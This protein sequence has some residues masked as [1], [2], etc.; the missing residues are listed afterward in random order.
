MTYLLILVDFQ[1]CKQAAISE[2][3]KSVGYVRVYKK[4]LFRRFAGTIRTCKCL[5][6][7]L[8]SQIV[9]QTLEGNLK[10]FLAAILQTQNY[11]TIAESMFSDESVRR[12]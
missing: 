4:M 3:E 8:R 9:L 1:L 7:I 11:D 5:S 12:F 10:R 6:S 2:E